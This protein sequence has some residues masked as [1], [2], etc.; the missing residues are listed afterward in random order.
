MAAL[1][2]RQLVWCVVLVLFIISDLVW[3]Y[4]LVTHVLRGEV[5]VSGVLFAVVMMYNYTMLRL[6]A[7]LLGSLNDVYVNESRLQEAE[8]KWKKDKRRKYWKR[9]VK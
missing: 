6:L 5:F 8:R 7:N 1:R 9:I 2:L 4:A 3:G